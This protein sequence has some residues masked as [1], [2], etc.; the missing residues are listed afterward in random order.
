MLVRAFLGLR[1]TRPH[2]AK[3]KSWSISRR[4][5]SWLS[6]IWK[7]HNRRRRTK[8]WRN[9]IT[10]CSENIW[11]WR[12]DHRTR[13]RAMVSSMFALLLHPCRGERFN[14]LR[15]S[16]AACAK[17][18]SIGQMQIS[19]QLENVG[20]ASDPFE[21]RAHGRVPDAFWKNPE[22]AWLNL[23]KIQ[24]NYGKICEILEKNS[25]KFSNF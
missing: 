3:A 9:T 19:A 6:R 16:G 24:Q 2:G 1:G 12:G 22:K 25:N 14:T 15:P 18:R 17:R 10:L 13:S 7:N 21:R 20:E 23:A 8:H 4:P 11:L 5:S